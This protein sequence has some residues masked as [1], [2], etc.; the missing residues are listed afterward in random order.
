M[1]FESA[2]A[3]LPCLPLLA[4]PA[5]SVWRLIRGLRAGTWKRPAWFGHAAW[6]SFFLTVLVWLRGFVSGGLN[7]EDTCRFVH[8]QPFDAAYWE[9][10]RDDRFRVFP[11][12][13]KCNADYDLVP[14]W[15][16]PTIVV[17]SVLFVISMVGLCWVIA[18]RLKRI[19][20]KERRH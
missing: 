3:L 8:H 10:H 20:E 17:L 4:I 16:N 13:N 7:G 9:A 19:S 11:L 6:A 15:V 1:T 2:A 18:P 14:V 5:F 12:S